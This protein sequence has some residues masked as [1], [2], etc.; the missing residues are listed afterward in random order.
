MAPGISS[1]LADT[2][3]LREF[4]VQL[5]ARVDKE[6]RV[7]HDGGRLEGTERGFGRRL[8]ARVRSVLER[9][10]RGPGRAAR[11]RAAVDAFEGLVRGRF[12]DSAVQETMRG[13]RATGDIRGAD[14]LAALGS[15]H[16]S[17]ARA[18]VAMNSV[19]TDMSPG[20][21]LMSPDETRR[22]VAERNGYSFMMS[23]TARNRFCAVYDRIF[24]G[25]MRGA[26]TRRGENF[27]AGHAPEVAAEKAARVAASFLPDTARSLTVFLDGMESARGEMA[28]LTAAL[29][30]GDGV[31][32][33]E[34]EA[35]AMV[36]FN[37]AIERAL[38]AIDDA[39]DATTGEG[40][41]DGLRAQVRDALELDIADRAVGA[42]VSDMARSGRHSDIDR[43]PDLPRSAGARVA[44]LILGAKRAQMYG[45]V[46]ASSL[47]GLG[48]ISEQKWS[49]GVSPRALVRL[50]DA[51][52]H[53][54]AARD[55]SVRPAWLDSAAAVPTDA[56]IQE[57]KGV[58]GGDGDSYFA[59]VLRQA[60]D[61]LGAA[62]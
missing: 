27:A 22:L 9:L 25:M 14:M 26:L 2:T 40:L 23:P 7:S 54:G 17:S 51:L 6:V 24:S 42:M 29:L 49:E 36:R 12:P 8:A 34:S 61:N 55:D 58:A 44:G 1:R 35:V 60:E 16:R 21:L 41:E 56:D 50:F 30:K 3:S 32:R 19:I 4:Q 46:K 47:G 15:L 18:D 59:A 53:T 37:G 57:L 38:D 39:M 62:T 10:G 28:T 33:S 11:Q 13:L 5:R 20:R 45:A 43:M 52:A 31:D 48:E